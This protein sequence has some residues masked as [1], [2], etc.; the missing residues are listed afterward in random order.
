M[1]MTENAIRRQLKRL[2][3]LP[4]APADEDIK[5]IN[6]ELQRIIRRDCKSDAHLGAVTDHLMDTAQRFPTVADLA[7]A[8][9]DIDPPEL[10]DYST[11][12]G[13]MGCE[14]CQGSGWRSY[15]KH[16]TLPNGVGYVAEFADFCDCAKGRWKRDAVKAYED[17]QKSKRRRA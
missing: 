8:F 10:P 14:A 7:A 11:D 6:D 16:V 13:P 4:F 3:R 1:A 2:Y 15:Q 9:R 12:R 5:P 17:G